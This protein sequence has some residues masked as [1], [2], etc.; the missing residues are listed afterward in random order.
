MEIAMSTKTSLL[1]AAVLTL[2]LATAAQAGAKDDGETGGFRV[3][4]LGQS[5]SQGVNPV[6]HRSLRN[7]A[8]K[9]FASAQRQPKSY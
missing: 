8:A 4:P 5:F 1:L 9:A 6:H 7:N 3:G 2:G